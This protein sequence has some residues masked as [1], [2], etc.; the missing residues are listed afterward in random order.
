LEC[1]ADDRAD[2]EHVRVD[3]AVVETADDDRLRRVDRARVGDDGAEGIRGERPDRTRVVNE[4]DGLFG[5]VQVD[6]GLVCGRRAGRGLR[7][8]N[9]RH[10]PISTKEVAGMSTS[11]PDPSSRKLGKYIPTLACRVKLSLGTRLTMPDT[12]QSIGP[13]APPIARPYRTYSCIDAAGAGMS[14]VW[15]AA[16]LVHPSAPG[17]SSVPSTC[18]EPCG[19]GK[20]F[21]MNAHR[22]FWPSYRRIALSPSLPLSAPFIV[23]TIP[24]DPF[25]R[26]IRLAAREAASSCV[27]WRSPH[28]PVH[29][30][31][32]MTLIVPSM[33]PVESIP[34]R[35]S[36][37]PDAS[38]RMTEHFASPVG[39]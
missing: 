18:D 31:I 16:P 8:E 7:V 17:T 11:I 21:A 4:A 3:P 34:V 23:A 10:Q 30:P 39:L 24:V 9:Q 13:P 15:P 33:Q 20:A 2:L 37:P 26:L 29:P 5:R 25:G 28:R 14:P 1:G 36:P 38:S 32:W 12:C 35:L 19:M 6:V 22:C 27:T